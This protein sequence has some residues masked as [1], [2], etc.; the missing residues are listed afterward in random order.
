ML[1]PFLKISDPGRNRTC[2]QLIRNQLLYPL[3]Y[4]APC[5]LSAANIGFLGQKWNAL[6][7]KLQIVTRH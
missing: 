7:I 4:G 6:A 1:K 2:G 3:S 5:F